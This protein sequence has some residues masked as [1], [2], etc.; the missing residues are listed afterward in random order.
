M[1]EHLRAGIAIHNA[2]HHHAAHDAWE[3]RWLEVKR[4]VEDA[5]ATV[6]AVT[7]DDGTVPADPTPAADERLLHGLIQFTAA[8]H[9]LGRDNPD[10]ARGLAESGRAY[11]DPLVADY[12]GVNVDAVR[13]YL[14]AVAADPG[15]TDREVPRLTHEGVALGFE[16]LEFPA[17]AVAAGVLAEE[18]GYDEETVA[19]GVEY[20]R[21]DLAAGD[22][23]SR[24]LT[25]VFDF[26]RDA[27]N[28]GIVAQRLGDHVSRRRH[29]EEDVEGLF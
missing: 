2:G 10:G 15:A 19:A 26:V 11:L 20:A 22:D 3:D 14:D 29:R 28:R 16:D 24:F 17:T 25:L 18:L 13:A 7:D 5:P 9:H 21:A 1:R 27:D 12:R 4:T 23:G 6:E 8:V